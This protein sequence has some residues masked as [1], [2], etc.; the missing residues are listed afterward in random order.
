MTE[1]IVYKNK[2]LNITKK[3]NYYFYDEN[4]LQVMILPIIEDKKFILVKQFRFPIKKYTYEF[5][6]GG[7]K[8][9]YEKTFKAAIRELYEETGILVK[10]NRIIKMNSINP[11]PQRQRK[12]VNIFMARIT[13][14]EFKKRYKKKTP[15]IKNLKVVNIGQL[16][17]MFKSGKIISGVMG[18]VFLQYLLKYKKQ[19]K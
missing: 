2:Y 7:C 18:L 3:K 19:K 11:N 10:K 13:F 16:L 1:K 17:N 5:P 8:N 9:R 4:N 12:F 6:A 15:E 14:E